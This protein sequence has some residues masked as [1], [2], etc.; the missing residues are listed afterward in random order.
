[1]GIII[2]IFARAIAILIVSK[3]LVGVHVSSFGAA[4]VAS[5][6]LGLVNTFLR[7]ILLLL[8]LPINLLSLGLFTFVINA[9]LFLFVGHVVAGFSVQ[10]F[11][12]AV[13][14]SLIVSL[15]SYILDKWFA[16]L[17]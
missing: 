6:I 3:L 12:T 8:T 7:P 4:V 10:G 1:M 17:E 2:G 16:K 14:G 11:G 13:L 15:I 5:I 9:L